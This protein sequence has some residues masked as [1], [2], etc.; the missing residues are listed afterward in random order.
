MD[1]ETKDSIANKAFQLMT[2]EK[3]N[4][5]VNRRGMFSFFKNTLQESILKSAD[6]FTVE[7]LED[8]TK[9][10][11]THEETARRKQF[12]ECIMSLGNILKEEVDRIVKIIK[13]YQATI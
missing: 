1:K 8:R 7:K 13:E 3:P 2:E 12:L 9:V 4:P 10:E 11:F 6:M 5:T